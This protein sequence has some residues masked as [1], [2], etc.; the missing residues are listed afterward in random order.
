MLITLSGGATGAT[1]ISVGDA[2]VGGAITLTNASTNNTITAGGSIAKRF[3]FN[4]NINGS[5][6]LTVTGPDATLVLN[7]EVGNSTVL[8]SFESFANLIIG[9]TT[10]IANFDI[11]YHST[12][13]ASE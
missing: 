4:N 12:C 8:D 6:A 11:V 5:G 3:T 13:T 7:G 9:G 1:L 2:T 10:T